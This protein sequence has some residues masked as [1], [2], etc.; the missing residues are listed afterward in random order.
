MK[1]LLAVYVYFACKICHLKKYTQ[2]HKIPRNLYIARRQGNLIWWMRDVVTI[3]YSQGGCLRIDFPVLIARY[4]LTQQ[5]IFLLSNSAS[6][7]S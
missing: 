3:P 7:I 6:S 1:C 4:V 2:V 5:G